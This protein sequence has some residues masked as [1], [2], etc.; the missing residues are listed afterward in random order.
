MVAGSPTEPLVTLVIPTFERASFL[1]DSISSLLAQDYGAL[2]IIVIDDG[3]TDDTPAILAGYAERHPERFSWARHDNIGQPGTLNRGF[4]MAKGE[5]LGYL[6]SD[7]MLLPAAVTKLVEPLVADPEAVASYGGWDYVDEDGEKMVSVIP[8]QFT[9][10]HALLRS[11]PVVGPGALFRRSILDV[12]GGWSDGIR[13]SPDFDFW[14]RVAS[15]G[16]F[17]LV[18][19][20]LALYRWHEQMTGRS[21][22]GGQIAQE[23]IDIV[24]RVYAESGLPDEI[25]AI[26]EEAYRSAFLAGATLIGGNALWER[27]FVADRLIGMTFSEHERELAESTARLEFEISARERELAAIGDE[28]AALGDALARRAEEIDQARA[29]VAEEGR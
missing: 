16:R 17:A 12:V 7:D 19:E 24:D 18:P 3:S 8:I 27:F 9:R 25:L 28:I 10:H 22:V 26:K 14:L 20:R 5:I 13:F 1:D 15:V 11:D 29:G 2:E 21:S 4:A 23:R 6:S